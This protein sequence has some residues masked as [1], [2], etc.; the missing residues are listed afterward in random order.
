[1][2]EEILSIP[3]LDNV[4]ELNQEGLLCN[5]QNIENIFKIAEQYSKMKINFD[6][7]YFN[8]EGYNKI[9]KLIRFHIKQID[10]IFKGKMW[11]LEKF[12]KF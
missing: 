7:W 4:K 11:S 8:I 5:L 2:T 10:L 6:F 3:F 12:D 1:M 9:T